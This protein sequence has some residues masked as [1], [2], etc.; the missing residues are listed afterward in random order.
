MFMKKFAFGSQVWVLWKGAIHTGIYKGNEYFN[1]ERH[2]KVYVKKVD[3]TLKI[4]DA[5]IFETKDKLISS[6]PNATKLYG[7]S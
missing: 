4:E 6:F 1:Y 5:H 7:V 2:H 3:N